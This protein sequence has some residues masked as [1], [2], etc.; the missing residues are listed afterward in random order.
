MLSQLGSAWPKYK[1]ICSIGVS[2]C[3]QNVCVL[4]RIE[5]NIVINICK[6]ITNMTYFKFNNKFYKQKYGLPMG[7]P[8]SRVLAGLFLEFLESSPI[9]Y[10]LPSGTTCFGCVSNVFIFLPQDIRVEKIAE[11]L[12]S[13][14]PAV[15]F[16][17]ERGSNDMMPFLVILIVE[18]HHSLAFEV[19][20]RSM[21]RGDCIHFYS[22]H[23]NKIK[24]GL[25]K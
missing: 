1:Q 10:M 17:C 23:N 12:D 2:V 18:S 5:I 11:K 13:V 7:N 15:N 20:C 16:T 9:G 19:N 24:T 21:G 14:E 8:L 6:H 3:V 22:H 25:I 4:L